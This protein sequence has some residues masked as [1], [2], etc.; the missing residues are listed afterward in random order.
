MLYHGLREPLLTVDQH[1]D[2]LLHVKWT[3]KVRKEIEN[4]IEIDRN[5]KELEERK[6]ERERDRDGSLVLYHGLREPLLTVD[7]RLDVLLHVKWTV[8]V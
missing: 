2:A 6:G 1:L 8:K 7:Q 5:R 3:V 4:E